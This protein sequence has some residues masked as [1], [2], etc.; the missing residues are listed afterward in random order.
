MKKL[1]ILLI[2]SICNQIFP[3]T[4]FFGNIP[5]LVFRKET[6]RT[7]SQSDT[8][9][10]HLFNFHFVQD[11]LKTPFLYKSPVTLQGMSIF[12][13]G[14]RL[15]GDSRTIFGKVGSAKVTSK[16]V[17]D[18]SDSLLIDTPTEQ[19]GI[20]TYAKKDKGR[21]SYIFLPPVE[22]RTLL[23]PDMLVFSRS[24]S[25]GE[26]QRIETYLSIKYG[27]SINYISE[28]NY[29]SSDGKTIWDFKNNRKYGYRIT[30]I[31]RDDAFA[32]YQK[33]STNIDKGTVTFA[34]VSKTTLNENN[35]GSLENMD[36]LLWGD[37]NEET[38]FPVE[39]LLS[40]HPTGNM[41][42]VWKLQAKSGAGINTSVYFKLNDNITDTEIPRLKIFRTTEDF[43]NDV[44]ELY[45][46]EKKDSLIVYKNIT[47]DLDHNGTDYFTLNN[48]QNTG[49]IS[50]VSTCTELQ[51]GTIKIN[52][53]AEAN[54]VSYSVINTASNVVMLNQQAFYLNQIVLNNLLSGRYEIL[55]HRSGNLPDI[56]KVFDME[57]MYNQNVE[58]N[59]LWAGVPIELDINYEHYRYSLTK[60][61][62]TI[63]SH[64]P[65]LL[66]GEGTYTLR[67]K[68]RI[69]CE[70]EKHLRVLNATD[71][72]MQNAA[73]FFRNII[74]Y[75]NPSRDGNVT[76]KVD[77]RVP[78]PITVH[79]YNSL[80][81][82]LK[83]AQFGSTDSLTATLSIPAVVGYYN[84]KIFIP[85]E[86]KGFNFLIH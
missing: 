3:Q 19:P 4:T 17:F 20:I 31:G 52:I 10:G 5:D 34:T 36:F 42:R 78:K 54:A 69:G 13:V 30:G 14:D 75:P 46:G 47:W 79:I 7:P 53:P 21:S 11:T 27:I 71:Y 50:V 82:L 18:Y 67:V 8:L 74:L 44:A 86:S 41:L 33:Q 25:D 60:P 80:G 59:Y 72:A 2:L 35:T 38:V 77:L 37:N 39:D 6:V 83:E 62:G 49:R 43:Q 81:K 29:L 28:R 1:Y 22:G 76:V 9:K 48:L 84:I 65:F 51:S 15:G 68:N 57:G 23:V 70:L 56:K 73:S 63:V 26:K 85:E 12:Y 61:N 55:I 45:T 58:D 24:L 64:P 32:L 40:M 16:G 66:E